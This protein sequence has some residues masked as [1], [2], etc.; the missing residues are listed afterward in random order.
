MRV[1]GL[2][3]VVGR[4]GLDR[5]IV[6]LGTAVSL[7][8]SAGTTLTVSAN[9]R[10]PV[11]VTVKLPPAMSLFPAEAAALTVIV[12]VKAAFTVSSET[13]L[14]IIVAVKATLAVVVTVS[15]KAP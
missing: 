13:S 3:T 2:L 9:R 7:T 5:G 11:I 14:T 12:T 10:R 6:A 8:R 1:V 15:V 4:L